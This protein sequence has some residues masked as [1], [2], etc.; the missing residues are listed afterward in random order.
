MMLSYWGLML[1]Q[2]NAQSQGQQQQESSKPFLNRKNWYSSEDKQNG[3]K[4]PGDAPTEIEDIE[5]GQEGHHTYE[6]YD[7]TEE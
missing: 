1:V 7:D 2:D 3:P 6:E 4:P 5:S